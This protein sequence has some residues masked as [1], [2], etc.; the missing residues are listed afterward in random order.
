MHVSKN[1]ERGKKQKTNKKQKIKKEV[2]SSLPSFIPSFIF[3]ISTNPDAVKWA[4]FWF[5]WLA[6]LNSEKYFDLH[7]R[8]GYLSRKV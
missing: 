2:Y 5:S 3:L 6:C 8:L 7:P 4:F 1:Y